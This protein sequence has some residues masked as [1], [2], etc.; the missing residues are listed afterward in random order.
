VFI[1]KNGFH[2]FAN[3][4]LPP[5]KSDEICLIIGAALIAGHR[6]ATLKVLHHKLSATLE[7]LHHK[8][9]RLEMTM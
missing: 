7:V 1:K 3:K 5:E 2:N 8:P 6:S 4:G 9:S